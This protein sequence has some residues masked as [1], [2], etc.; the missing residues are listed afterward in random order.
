MPRAAPPPQPPDAPVAPL[1]TDEPRRASAQCCVGPLGRSRR[2]AGEA[3][4]TDC[5]K[6]QPHRTPGAFYDA[7]GLLRRLTD[8]ERAL[9]HS[10]RR[11]TNRDNSLVVVPAD[12]RRLPPARSAAISRRR[13]PVAM[14]SRSS[15]GPTCARTS[16][17]GTRQLRGGPRAPGTGRRWRAWR[18]CG[19]V[20]R[21][22]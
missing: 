19:Q 1:A 17:A 12:R 15:T 3:A 10:R 22:A 11:A 5:D 8:R 4:R 7:L 6:R 2:R 14:R 20:R 9:S 16:R 18:R 21:S 13:P